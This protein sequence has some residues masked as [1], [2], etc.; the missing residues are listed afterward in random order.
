MRRADG[1]RH[2]ARRTAAQWRE[3][4]GRFER[5]GQSRGEFCAAHRLAL[6]SFDLWQRKLRA[7]PAAVEE[8]RPEARFVGLTNPAHTRTSSTSSRPIDGGSQPA[9][10]TPWHTLLKPETATSDAVSVPNDA[11]CPGV[12][13]ARDADRIALEF[14][15]NL[16]SAGIDHPY[17]RLIIGSAIRYDE[18]RSPV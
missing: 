10:R 8:A 18:P 2:R 15:G 12:G 13:P 1:T 11:V 17:L 16:F 6:S 7:T 4:V 5:A 14:L 3:L 9:L